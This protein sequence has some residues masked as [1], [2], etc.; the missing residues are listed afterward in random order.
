MQGKYAHSLFFLF[1]MTRRGDIPSSPSFLFQCGEEGLTLLIVFFLFRRDK[2]LSPLSLSFNFDVTRRDAP[3][4][5]S[6]YLNTTREFITPVF[7]FQF[8]CD[9]EGCS[10]LVFFLFWHNEEGFTLLIK[11]FLFDTTMDY[12]PCRCISIL[13]WWGGLPRHIEFVSFLKS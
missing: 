11:F 7:V 13:M 10:L 2:E 6:F 9:E 3:P 8:W 4:S 12:H 1:N 5:C